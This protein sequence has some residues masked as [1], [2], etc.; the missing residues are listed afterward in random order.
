MSDPYG[1]GQSP[2]KSLSISGWPSVSDYA[3]GICEAIDSAGI[4]VYVV[5]ANAKLDGSSTSPA[6]EVLRDCAFEERVYSTAKSE[7]NTLRDRI[8][9]DVSASQRLRLVR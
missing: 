9:K 5:D 4:T 2:D 3:K 6:A 8:L 7:V 1:D